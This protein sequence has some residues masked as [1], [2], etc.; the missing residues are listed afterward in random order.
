MCLTGRPLFRWTSGTERHK[1][2]ISDAHGPTNQDRATQRI[3]HGV[4]RRMALHHRVLATG[5]LESRAR[6]CFVAV[7]PWR[8]VPV[9]SSLSP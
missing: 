7:L 8:L 1:S 6:D 9:R 2:Q 3:G 5:L 4:V